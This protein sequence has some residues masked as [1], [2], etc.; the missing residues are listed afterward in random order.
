MEWTS[1]KRE[2]E[3]E[4]DSQIESEFR[5]KEEKEEMECFSPFFAFTSDV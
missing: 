5:S 4:R 2:R 3:G 1:K